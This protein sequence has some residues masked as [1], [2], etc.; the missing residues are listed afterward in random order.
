MSIGQ[1]AILGA[2]AVVIGQL[3]R[4]RSL[5]L[6]GVSAF[7]IYWLQPLQPVVGLTFWFPLGTLAVTALAWLLTS[8]PEK[9]GWKQNLPALA[10]L[11][12]V[13]LL[14]DLNRYF[15]FESLFTS[16]APRPQLVLAGVAIVLALGLVLARIQKFPPSLFVIAGI[17]LVV[18]LACLK[19]PSAL[20][21]LFAAVS[22][23]WG[24]E[25]NAAVP[26]S[27]LGYSYLSFRLLHTILDRKAGR[28]PSVLLAE[29][30]NY[31]VFF[32]SFTAGPIDRL[33][34]FVRDLNHP[35]L[36]DREGWIDAGGRLFVGLFKKF[37]IA[38]AL[39]WVALTDSFAEQVRSP[40]WM[41]VLL[42][43]YSFRIYFDFSGYTDIAIGLGR[44]LGVR[45]SENFASPYLKPNIAQFWNSWH[46]T[47]TQWF[48]SYFFNPMNRAW[49]TGNTTL[50]AW[51][52]I[53]L[54]QVSTMLLIGLWHGLTLGFVLWGLWHGMGLFVHNRWSEYVK[55][56]PPSR[57][58]TRA[59]QLVSRYAG[60]FLTFNFV[61][62]GWLFFTLPTPA[63][64]WSV[65]VKMFGAA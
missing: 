1:I 46:M 19:A 24:R 21:A 62:I 27:W 56:H 14:V 30:V 51:L 57:S 40:G 53:L 61:S 36:L 35:I 45:L 5:A 41:W 9:R 26:L 58:Q 18:V 47:L 7:A 6:L 16:A 22:S 13:I 65:L 31:V 34:R 59:G 17:G 43:L 38:D 39:A 10:V 63:M 49:R 55:N 4:D 33:E 42:Y 11:L 2:V 48:Q 3:K 32:P 25:V 28:L 12:G 52:M 15:Q 60:V 37:V 50:P 64:A 20:N 44:L 54:A 8:A 23:L 29:Y